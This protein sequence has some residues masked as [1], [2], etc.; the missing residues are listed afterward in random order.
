MGEEVEGAGGL[1]G[2]YTRLKMGEEVKLGGSVARRKEPRPAAV[3]ILPGLR[4]WADAYD[5]KKRRKKKPK[6]R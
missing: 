3:N 6:C 1:C 2:T 5:K 4:V